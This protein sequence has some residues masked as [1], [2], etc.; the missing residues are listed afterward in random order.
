VIILHLYYLL[1]RELGKVRAV[2]CVITRKMLILPVFKERQ[3]RKVKKEFFPMFIN[4][5]VNCAVNLCL[6][7]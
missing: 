3:L 4:I 5:L 2:N 7:M 6:V 1:P